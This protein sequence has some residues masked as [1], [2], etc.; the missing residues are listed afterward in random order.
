MK[1]S[2]RRERVTTSRDDA[3]EFGIR[4]WKRQTDISKVDE[5][6]VSCTTLE[7]EGMVSFTSEDLHAE[8][9]HASL[10]R[11]SWS[12]E[13]GHRQMGVTMT[14]SPSDQHQRNE[15]SSA[16]TGSR[17]KSIGS[18][19]QDFRQL[20]PFRMDPTKL[21]HESPSSTVVSD[22]VWRYNVAEFSFP[23]PHLYSLNVSRPFVPTKNGP[24]FVV[25][26]DERP[27][28][29]ITDVDEEVD[30]IPDQ[31][32]NCK[33]FGIFLVVSQIL[34]GIAPASSQL[35]SVPN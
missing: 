19:A 23:R 20:I 12:T 32:R 2:S 9:D 7:I 4:F 11:D 10:H 6:I 22:C 25:A 35:H 30:G 28:P 24:K 34:L 1:K 31:V 13:H 16:F 26:T 15:S 3:K 21:N 27:G 17:R 8:C 14:R 18:D 29:V 33:P 5:G